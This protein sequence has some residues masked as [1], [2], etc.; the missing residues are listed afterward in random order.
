MHAWHL[1]IAVHCRLREKDA[2]FLT[3]IEQILFQLEEVLFSIYNAL[4]V[5]FWSNN[6]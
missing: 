5:A 6:Q 2:I 1:F 3:Y 4:I